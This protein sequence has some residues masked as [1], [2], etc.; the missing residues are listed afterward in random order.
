M[1][2]RYYNSEVNKIDYHTIYLATFKIRDD[3]NETKKLK[4]EF[5]II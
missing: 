4:K 3:H 1:D 2:E 5:N